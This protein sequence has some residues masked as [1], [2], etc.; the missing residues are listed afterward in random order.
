MV[1]STLELAKRGFRNFK[2]CVHGGEILEAANKSLR[3]G[4]IRVIL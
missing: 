4:G 1:K 2:P 3:K